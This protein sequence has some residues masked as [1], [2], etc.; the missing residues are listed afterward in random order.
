MQNYLD[1]LYEYSMKWRLCVNI[2]KTKIMIFRKGGRLSNNL[3]FKYGNNPIE[4]VNSYLVVVFTT[5]GSFTDLQKT[6]VG[7]AQK[8]MYQMQKYLNHFVSLKPSR[9]CDIFDKLI[10]PM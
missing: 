6:L 2:E 5:G 8:G 7:Q 4:I 10:H 3:D 1:A 9:V